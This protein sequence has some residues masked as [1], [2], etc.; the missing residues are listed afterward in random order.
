MNYDTK[1]KIKKGFIIFGF[2][3]V[4]I[5]ISYLLYSLFFKAPEE[6][7]PEEPTES[8]WDFLPFVGDREEGAELE[9]EDEDV[10]EDEDFVFDDI[11]DYVPEDE[12]IY[13]PE[14]S[15]M[16]ESVEDLEDSFS[17][18]Q[19]VS[20]NLNRGVGVSQ[21]GEALNY[22]DYD[23]Q[24]F[25]KI[26][27][28]GDKQL[29]SDK[30]F[31]KVQDVTWSPTDEKAI[32]EYPDGQK[33][34]Y[35]FNNDKQY[36]LPN[37]WE[38]FDFD[39]Q[40]SEIA[41]KEDNVQADYRWLSTANPDGS[42]KKLVHHLGINADD[43]QVGYSPNKQIIAQYPQID[44][45]SRSKV[46]FLGANDENF[47]AIYVDGADVKTQWSPQ[48]NSLLASSY[49]PQTDFNP[50]LQIIDYDPITNEAINKKTINLET[51]ADKCTYK[52]ENTILCAV[53]QDMVSGAGMQPDVMKYVP[54]DLYEIDVQTGSTKRLVENLQS[55]TMS[56]LN[57]GPDGNLYF[58]D[59]N[60]GTLNKINLK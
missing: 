42:N 60:D 31:Y 13:I 21:E 20:L 48:G 43:V 41:F 35:N 49:S 24:R 6:E 3:L 23:E 25:Y 36:T 33:V 37:N 4:I 56:D 47:S 55:Y 16:P 51:W 11:D 26:D 34:F 9:D 50:Q 44:N 40:G 14:P 7:I 1:E 10:D 15:T 8:V 28:N 58:I 53:P 12:Q 18:I 22:Y 59:Q 17:L 19:P 52:D 39:D 54:D 2:L 57:I 46:Y 38:E 27:E 32:L 29:L 5:V 45:L 30:K